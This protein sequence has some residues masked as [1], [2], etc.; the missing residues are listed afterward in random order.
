MSASSPIVDSPLV[1]HRG[2]STF[3]PENTLAA[4]RMAASKGARWIETDV[5][6]TADGG[7]VMIHDATLDRTTSGSGPV[8]TATLEAIR[9]F[10][11]GGWFSPDFA[12]ERVPDLESFLQA[13]VDTGLN[14]QLE[15]KQNWGLEEPLVEAVVAVIRR[16]WPIGA[17]GLYVSSFS[18]RCMQLSA[19]ALPEV[20]RALATEFVPV[21]PVRRLREARCQILH[22]Q[23][24]L[25]R[26]PELVRLRDADIEFAVATVNDVETARRFLA[27]GATSVLTDRVDL[28]P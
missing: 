8:V 14:L 10:D 18:E 3:A 23:A 25:T 12:G 5:R 6:L 22:T 1:V 13:V 21:D 16:V 7:L 28:F 19:E 11:A 2:A 20:P 9:G 27:A 17:R 4:V 15:L 26:E 24:V